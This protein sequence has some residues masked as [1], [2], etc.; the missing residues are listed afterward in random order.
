MKIA[1]PLFPRTARGLGVVLALVCG[2]LTLTARGPEVVVVTDLVAGTDFVAPTAEA[3]CYYLFRGGIERTIGQSVAREPIPTWDEVRAALE[4]ELARQHYR[5]TQVGGPVPRLVF[6]CSWGAANL[7]TDDFEE[8]DDETGDAT[9]VTV[10]SNERDLRR[11]AGAAKAERHALSLVEADRLQTVLNEDRL[12]VMIAAFDAAALARHEK[13]LVWRTNISIP[14]R[15]HALPR[16]LAVMMKSAGPHFGRDTAV[17]VMVDDRVRNAEVQIGT[18][19][20]M[21]TD[22]QPSAP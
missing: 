10:N 5:L 12:Y 11:L 20:V 14:S 19:T 13:R 18:A 21:E 1:F 15:H 16:E 2:A 8:T 9:T 3:P 7:V 17:P 6:F 4:P 22:V